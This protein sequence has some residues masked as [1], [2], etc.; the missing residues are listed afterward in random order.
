MHC[1]CLIDQC[2]AAV[3]IC[4][5]IIMP[6][7]IMYLTSLLVHDPYIERS[8]ALVRR[9]VILLVI[10]YVHRLCNVFD[11]NNKSVILDFA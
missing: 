9:V 4:T 11:N 6:I 7:S 5:I 2:S 8:H 3:C 1:I 10:V